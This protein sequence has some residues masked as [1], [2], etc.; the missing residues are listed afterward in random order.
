MKG[1]IH[2]LVTS[3]RIK[4]ALKMHFRLVCSIKAAI[5][6]EQGATEVQSTSLATFCNACRPSCNTN[7]SHRQEPRERELTQSYDY[8]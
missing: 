1:S 3:C 5:E 6:I 4:P 8:R 2:E 7:L